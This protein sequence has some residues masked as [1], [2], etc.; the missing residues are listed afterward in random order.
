MKT[1]TLLVLCAVTSFALPDASTIKGLSDG[2]VN[3]EQSLLL[4]NLMQQINVSLTNAATKGLYDVRV[5][6]TANLR[7]NLLFLA[8]TKLREHGYIVTIDRP[9]KVLDIQWQA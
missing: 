4:Q 6:Y 5:P 8:V 2:V 7:Y 9:S 3:H 1:L